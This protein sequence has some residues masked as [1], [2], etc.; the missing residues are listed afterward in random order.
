MNVGNGDTIGA[1]ETFDMDEQRK[2]SDSEKRQQKSEQIAQYLL[3][4]VCV[5]EDGISKQTNVIA[6]LV[7]GYG[8]SK[9]TW[10]IRVGEALPLGIPQYAMNM[11]G[12]KY[13]MTRA[14][15]GSATSTISINKELVG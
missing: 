13:R 7:K 9:S 10:K 2:I 11:V 5:V 14:K 15:R 1:H 8:A 6:L 4:L 3:D 12:Q